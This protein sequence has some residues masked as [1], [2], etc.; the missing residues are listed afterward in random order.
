MGLSGGGEWG[1]GGRGGGRGEARA[2]GGGGTVMGGGLIE[3][4]GA[5]CRASGRRGVT[6]LIYSVLLPVPISCFWNIL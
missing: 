3:G 1:G 6:Y 2:G 5:G 4:V